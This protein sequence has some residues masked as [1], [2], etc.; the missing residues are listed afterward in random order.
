MK[1]AW[2]LLA[3]WPL[4]AAVDGVVMNG[5]SAKPQAG[6]QVALMA[7]S[8]QGMAPLGSATS[9]AQGKFR[10]DQEG[11]AG[12]SILQ[13]TFQGV[14][15]TKVLAPGQAK[16][17]LTFEVFDASNQG[18]GVSV[19]RHGILLEPGPERLT[20]REFVFLNNDSKVTY[21]D[22]AR[23]TFRFF[24]PGGAQGLKVQLTP[25]GG[26]PVTR[27]A[28][29]SGQP[30]IYKV[31]YAL[32]PGQTQVDV[33]YTLA[34]AGQFSGR[35]LHQEGTTRLIVPR[36]VKLEGEGLEAFEPE[37]RTQ[38]P[39]YGFKEGSLKAGLFTV[40]ISGQPAPAAAAQEEDAGS[41]EVRPLRPRIYDKV[42][43]VVGLASA[44]LVA[45]LFVVARG[46]VR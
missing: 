46:G 17:G 28:E 34:A 41:P 23:G 9:D 10:I 2:V 8:E 33:E 43:W 26:M 27:E 3:A 22:P 16:T 30:N 14:T 42:T 7:A 45:G 32:R 13:A 1:G 38:S 21:H 20:V 31:N 19:E 39:I 15:Y 36:G 25:P 29:K 37:P 5:G 44:I 6:V 35:L 18:T 11:G 24:A 12:P 40:K 4:A